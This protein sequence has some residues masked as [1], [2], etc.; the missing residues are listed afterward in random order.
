MQPTILW[1]PTSTSSQHTRLAQ[2]WAEWSKGLT[3]F[4]VASAQEESPGF[5]QK[6]LIGS[7]EGWAAVQ[8]GLDR[9]ESE[10]W[11]TVEVQWPAWWEEQHECWKVMRPCLCGMYKGKG[12]ERGELGSQKLLTG[13]GGQE[14][15]PKSPGHPGGCPKMMVV[16]GLAEAL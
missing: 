3:L 4:T 6:W 11:G 15:G 7:W 14:Q 12:N 5:W 10:G 9:N 16:P 13:R 8:L 2:G 1:L